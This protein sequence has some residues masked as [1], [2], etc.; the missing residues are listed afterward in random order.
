M[1]RAEIFFQPEVP[2]DLDDE[3]A[4]SWRD[5]EVLRDDMMGRAAP[6]E[7]TGSNIYGSKVQHGYKYDVVEE[8]IDAP[9]RMPDDYW[10]VSGYNPAVSACL[11]KSDII[12]SHIAAGIQIIARLVWE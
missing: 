10:V 12:L 2:Y 8:N 7:A 9:D 1:T 5:P 3:I 6:Q 4:D 11:V